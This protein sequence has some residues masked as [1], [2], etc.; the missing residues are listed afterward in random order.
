MD[1]STNSTQRHLTFPYAMVQALF[2]CT[3][4]I[5]WS[6]TAVLLGACGYDSRV[7]GLVTG[8]GAV[9]SVALQPLMASLAIKLQFL[10]TKR[11]VIM[12]KLISIA[13]AMIMMS[14]IPGV[15]TVAVMFTVLTAIDASIPSMLNNIAME[16]T[17]S[18]RKLDF[19][20]ARGTGSIAYAV[21]SYIIGIIV[22]EYGSRCLIWMYIILGIMV[23]A[24]VMVLPESKD[25]GSNIIVSE[26]HNAGIVEVL[27]KYKFLPKFL[28]AS[29]LL[30]MGHN[31][32][33]VFLPDIVAAAGGD[34]SNLGAAIC[35]SAV[36]ELPVMLLFSTISSRV[37]VS[38]LLVMSS[39][40]FTI[41][42]I[43]AMLSVNV[44]M[45]EAVQL[46]QAGAF[47]IYT[48]ASIFY[49]NERMDGTDS[50]LGQALTGACTLG[51]GGML[52]NIIGGYVLQMAGIRAMLM[53]ASVFSILGIIFM[54][55]CEYCIQ[56]N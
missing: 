24:A 5:S 4:A 29:V 53:T 26:K 10:N 49:I 56:K 11:N 41:K 54:V 25:T 52:G 16:E 51:F 34:N 44:L 2:W 33:N 32:Q 31:M 43:L 19:G 48:P 50:G 40:F 6:Y 35:L 36:A 13:A 3:Y 45:L 14:N 1:D 27:R 38:R 28:L 23:T 7:T 55:R 37:R 21:F 18:G 12:L 15:Y 30:F 46:L 47:A 22:Q 9:I 39:V 17:N 20:I 42:C 8:I